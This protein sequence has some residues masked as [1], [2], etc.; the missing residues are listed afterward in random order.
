[1]LA[2]LK[3]KKILIILSNFPKLLTRS[4]L[5]KNNRLKSPYVGTEEDLY[6]FLRS[7]CTPHSSLRVLCRGGTRAR[8]GRGTGKMSKK[9]RR[10][11]KLDLRAG[12]FTTKTSF[13]DETGDTLNCTLQSSDLLV[14]D[15]FDIFSAPEDEPARQTG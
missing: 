6:F 11:G 10:D 8:K 13:Y 2:L 7:P 4:Y 1:V 14:G 12:N 9:S 15:N 5:R 3:S